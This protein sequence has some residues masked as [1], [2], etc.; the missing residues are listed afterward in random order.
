M[1]WRGLWAACSIARSS[2]GLYSMQRLT[3]M[4]QEAGNQ[5][6]PRLLAL[7]DDAVAGLVRR[8]LDRTVEQ[9]LVLDAAAHLDA[10]GG[11][12]DQDGLGVV[13]AGRELVRGEAAEDHGVDGADPGTGQHRDQRLGHHRHVDD[14]PVTLAGTVLDQGAGEA[15]DKILELGVGDRAPAVGDRAVVDDRGLHAAA[16]GDVAVD[17][18]VAG[19]E[20]AAVEPA[21]EG[22][23]V[24]I[25]DALPLAVPVQRF[26]GLRPELVRVLERAFVDLPVRAQ[27][28]LPVTLRAFE[29][30]G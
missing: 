13:D 6:R 22:R 9:R 21:V 3:S 11:G 2:S 30:A 26:G 14:D 20:R 24:G 27:S 7:E 15:A 18:V 28:G 4:P 8:L 10:A 12:D 17:G 16:G 19:V 5:A 29:S 25:E 1:Q 23:L